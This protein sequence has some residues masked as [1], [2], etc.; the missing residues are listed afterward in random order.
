MPKFKFAPKETTELKKILEK[1]GLT[2]CF[3]GNSDLS[4]I[5]EEEKLAVS[6]VMH[7]AMIEVNEEGA[8]AAAA[9]AIGIMRMCIVFN[10][11]FTC[12]KPFLYTISNKDSGSILFMG[13][14]ANP[15][16]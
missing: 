16:V 11:K 7:K 14:V 12:N 15:L 9:T 2:D 5:S 10:P 8:E 3:N 4:L 13:K 6:T 1:L